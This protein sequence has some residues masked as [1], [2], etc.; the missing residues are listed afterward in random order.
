MGAVVNRELVRLLRRPRALGLVGFVVVA[1]VTTVLSLYP[2]ADMSP[3]ALREAS[4]HIFAAVTGVLFV[5]AVL[6][7]PPVAASSLVLE[8]EQDTYA[9]LWLTLLGPWGIVISKALN[10]VGYYLLMACA[11]LPVMCISAFLIGVDVPLVVFA[12][13]TV[14]ATAVSSASIGVVCSAVG[15][16][17]TGAIF[18]SYAVIFLVLVGYMLPLY[19]V[20]FVLSLLVPSTYEWLLLNVTDFL[21]FASPVSS[22][23][24]IISDPASVAGKFSAPITALVA[25]VAVAFGATAYAARILARPS[26]KR[27]YLNPIGVGREGNQAR[28]LQRENAQQRS[29]PYALRDV[30]PPLPRAAVPQPR[31]VDIEYLYEAPLPLWPPVRDEVNPMFARELIQL[32]LDTRV[33]GPRAAILFL[34]GA[35]IFGTSF[36][37]AVGTMSG[38]ETLRLTQIWV[39]LGLFGAV[40]LAPV[41]TSA[42]WAR[43]RENE[44]FDMLRMTTLTPREIVSG[45]ALAAIR[46]SYQFAVS[47]FVV[48]FPAAFGLLGGL[49]SIVLFVAGLPTVA[50]TL[51]E[52]VAFCLLAGMGGERT[53]ATMVAGITWLTLLHALPVLASLVI[54]NNK[55]PIYW[56]CFAAVVSPAI[57]FNLLPLASPGAVFVMV[58]M[59]LVS[60][61]LHAANA[62][63]LL[64][65]AAARYAQFYAQAT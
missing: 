25:Q 50:V 61:G 43:E 31:V 32:R 21:F 40:V 42:R 48:S 4:Q 3:A 9:L 7:L 56:S 17:T 60:C 46:A 41:A 49:D 10:A 36:L 57:A 29:S 18:A 8:R 44:T 26:E 55:V 5:S 33:T 22:L 34:V 14:I 37:I 58:I 2:D 51:L 54:F 53:P 28:P 19:I 63:V 23:G 24:T 20:R 35:V 11:V 15:Q 12:F 52:C 27:M 6:L 30:P 39:N 16:S 47:L 45:K 62:Y 13:L 59:W 1:A 65:W 64:R 38:G